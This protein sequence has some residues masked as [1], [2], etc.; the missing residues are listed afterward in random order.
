MVACQACG[1]EN[2][3]GAKFCYRCGTNLDGE[4]PRSNK[5]E[6][7][8][9]SDA[10][11]QQASENKKHNDTICPFCQAPNCQPMQKSST[12]IE[13]KNYRWGQ[14]CCGMFLLGPFGLLCGL[15]GTGSKI[16]SESVLWWTCLTCGKQHIALSDA[17]KKWE[18]LINGL[19]VTGISTAVAAQQQH[20]KAVAAQVT[21]LQ[22]V[23]AQRVGGGLLSVW[24]DNDHLV[25]AQHPQGSVFVI[26][27]QGNQVAQRDHRRGLLLIHGVEADLAFIGAVRL[28]QGKNGYRFA[29]G[30]EDGV[31]DKGA[32][33]ID[34]N[35]RLVK[36]AV[37]HRDA[38][39]IA[40]L[41]GG[42]SQ[43]ARLV[44]PPIK[45][46][47]IPIFYCL[48]LYLWM[49]PLCHF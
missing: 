11:S 4:N 1:A 43:P 16:K 36:G 3:D 22:I 32:G 9:S 20:S 2:P 5:Q 27:V 45:K 15:C 25:L 39:L 47:N 49:L 35:D 18:I 13:H 23:A 42:D 8:K 38:T 21:A 31:H 10:A 48:L 12:E 7:I 26:Q 19:P 14:G 30:G 24:G 34:L 28:P 6:P 33:E 17:K 44:D 29:V 40:A 37:V 41:L 46:S